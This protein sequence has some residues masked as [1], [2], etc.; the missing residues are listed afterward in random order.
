MAP[1]LFSETIGDIEI[2]AP[3]GTVSIKG[4]K[5]LNAN[6][7]KA[8]VTAAL[9]GD[10]AL[11][12]KLD[13]EV[14]SA[15]NARFVQNI[16][17]Y[18]GET[19]YD[20]FEARAIKGGVIGMLNMPRSKVTSRNADESERVTIVEGV[21]IES[22]DVPL[23]L[24]WFLA[25]DPEGMAEFAPLHRHYAVKSTRI[26]DGGTTLEIGPFAISGIKI[27]PGR[28]PVGTLFTAMLAEA[29][30]GSAART[31][32]GDSPAGG[33]R[34][35]AAPPDSDPVA[36]MMTLADLW[37]AFELEPFS[38]EGYK[39]TGKKSTSDAAA[40]DDATRV[41]V[42]KLSYSG[43]SVRGFLQEG[44]NY[45]AK[46]GKFSLDKLEFRGDFTALLLSAVEKGIRARSGTPNPGDDEL[47]KL[48]RARL[49]TGIPDVGFTLEG[50]AGDFIDTKDEAESS[51]VVFSLG[52]LALNSGGFVG[53]TPTLIECRLENLDF[54]LPSTSKEAS[55]IALR[56]MGL[57]RVNL[58][59]RI[60]I[61]WTE[62]SQ[63]LAV[64][65]ISL[66]VA[67][68]ARLAISGE[69]SGLPRPFFEDPETNWPSA[70][71]AAIKALVVDVDNK[72]GIGKLIDAAAK[73]QKKTGE[74]LREE[75]SSIA[76][77]IIAGVL[78]GHPDASK[79]ARGVADFIRNP[80]S[81]R[82]RITAAGPNGIV[83]TDLAT[84]NSNP[85]EFV[86]KLRFE[87]EGK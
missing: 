48:V 25:S 4:V 33:D 46:G 12:A 1:R 58:D 36:L 53:F 13:A 31:A 23:V 67:Q 8:E 78:A 61:G 37:S 85:A 74:Q 55:V 10:V 38:I 51:R 26:D 7:N 47:R 57:E 81:L 72:G 18:P 68:L 29:K 50:L 84:L 27:R 66:D 59:M 20:A 14:V 54:P 28:R 86:Q 70:M 6:L 56:E 45:V 22:F 3:F 17:G 80:N 71:G 34:P 41:E 2:S 75:Y 44:F 65:E 83:L 82:L 24:R 5:T 49:A 15:E 39:F 52:R 35:A 60:A 87:V 64:K 77:L 11:L 21:S 76:P 63:T 79:L 30:A 16:A 42:R 62:A 43:G 73:E 19:F 32:A 69:I 9:Q 40:P